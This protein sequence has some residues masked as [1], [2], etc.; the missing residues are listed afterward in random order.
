[1]TKVSHL[2]VSAAQAALAAGEIT[3]VELTEAYLARINATEP[4]IR[5]FLHLTPDT[6]LAA[7]H[8]SDERRRR[9]RPLGPLDG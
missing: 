1:M 7:A 4:L 6:A 9:G 2:T 3:A 5:A 8:A